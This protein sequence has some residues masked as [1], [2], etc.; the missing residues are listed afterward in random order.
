MNTCRHINILVQT[1]TE[2]VLQ[3][4]RI[5]IEYRC[6]KNNFLEVN[7]KIGT[8]AI[9]ISKILDNL[10][11]IKTRVVS[12]FLYKTDDSSI[13]F[14]T[15][16]N[17]GSIK[18]EFDRLGFDPG[19][20]KYVFLTHSDSDHT[21]G[22]NLFKNAEIYLSTDEEQMIHKKTPR[23][24]GFSYNRPINKAY[25]TL[26]G[27]DV[28]QAGETKVTAIATPGHTPGSMSYLVNDSILVVGDA[29]TLRKGKVRRLTRLQLRS[30]ASMDLTIQQESIKKLAKLRNISVMLTGHSGFTTNFEHAMGNYV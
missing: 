6:H 20:V 16:F 2:C 10:Y 19:D 27:G 17:E 5:I 4:Y 26:K 25:A 30:L 11:E 1:L 8:E 24:F 15:G 22:L 21:G 3:G 13:C 14:D 12:M 7:W 23:F 28:I 9:T 29:L 18:K